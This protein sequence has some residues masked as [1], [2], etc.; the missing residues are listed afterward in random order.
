MVK[1][2]TENT[3]DKAIKLLAQGVRVRDIQKETGIGKDSIYGLKTE[4]DIIKK[5]NHKKMIETE[6]ESIQVLCKGLLRVSKDAVKA[7][8]AEKIGAQTGA[9]IAT[10]LGIAIDKLQLITGGMIPDTN[11][12]YGEKQKMIDFLR[13]RLTAN[14]SGKVTITKTTETIISE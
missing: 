11:T 13:Q 1:K 12:H 10:T 14:K 2:L 5:A 4:A 9:A 6:T 7:L 8:T 3:K